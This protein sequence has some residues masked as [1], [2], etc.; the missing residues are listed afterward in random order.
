M[1]RDLSVR[2]C[3]ILAVVVILASVSAVSTHSVFAQR[4]MSHWIP[5]Q[6]RSCAQTSVG[7]DVLIDSLT[8]FP[9]SSLRVYCPPEC[10]SWVEYRIHDDPCPDCDP[11]FEKAWKHYQM[12]ACCDCGWGP[13]CDGWTTY[14][15][16]CAW[17]G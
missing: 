14:Q 9:R 3:G 17:C 6:V 12:R 11:P 5:V 16:E 2:V 7:T 4:G 15:Y 10:G 8:V 1:K 13:V